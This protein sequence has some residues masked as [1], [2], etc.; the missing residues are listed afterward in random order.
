MKEYKNVRSTVKPNE[1]ETDGY[2]VYINSDITE[3]EVITEDNKYTEYEFNQT[4]YSKD[5]YID[6]IDNKNK[7]LE[8][9]MIETQI[10][11]CEVYEK[12][13]VW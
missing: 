3:K 11:L 6:L 2:F 10:A 8:E 13:E 7:E 12:L 1:K 5:E 4:V 9:N